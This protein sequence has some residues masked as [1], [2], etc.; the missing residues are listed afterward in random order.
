MCYWVYFSI[1]A[2][3]ILSGF[4]FNKSSF[5]LKSFLRSDGYCGLTD[6]LGIPNL[7]K[8]SLVKVMLRR[9]Q[10]IFVPYMDALII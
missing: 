2:F 5:E 3:S 9:K 10:Q 7:F 6:A 4:D 1:Q 8:T